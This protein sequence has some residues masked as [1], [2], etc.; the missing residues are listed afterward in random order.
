MRETKAAIGGTVMRSIL[1]GAW[2]LCAGAIQA[3][4]SPSVRYLM[5]ESVSRF[6]W[7][8]FRLQSRAET[9]TWDGLDTQTPKQYARVQYGWE[10][11]Q[12]LVTLVVYPHYRNF[13]KST[14]RQVCGSLMSQMKSSFGVAPGSEFM[15]GIDG[16]GTFFRPQYFD[17]TDAPKT[18]DEDIE[19]ITT[20]QVDVMAS[21]NDQS[22]YQEMMSC[23]S[24]LRKAEVRY[25]VTESK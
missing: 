11:N 7:G 5:K 16:I 1:A 4:P 25:F 18:L 14:G 15:R 6:E 19:A 23:S 2:L 22:P 8:M 12:I 9:F 13:E 21:K 17:R 24:D 10:K 20:L 3:E